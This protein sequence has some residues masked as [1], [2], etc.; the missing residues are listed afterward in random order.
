ML[1]AAGATAPAVGGAMMEGEAAALSATQ[2]AALGGAAVMK[3]I[4]WLI[5]PKKYNS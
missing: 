3:G 1:A 5:T 4:G 2:M